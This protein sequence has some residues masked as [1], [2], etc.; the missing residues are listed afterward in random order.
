MI[1]SVDLQK[2]PGTIT[3]RPLDGSAPVPFAN[4]ELPSAVKKAGGAE[5]DW[6][7][8]HSGKKHFIVALA[9]AGAKL[10]IDGQVVVDCPAGEP[11][12]P[13]THR[14]SIKARASFTPS[15]GPHRVRIEL[16][17]HSAEQEATVLLAYANL[18]ICPWTEREIPNHAML[19]I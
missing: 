5:W 7:S 4:G 16:G 10:S 17:S 6:T 9:R 19:E 1:P 13:A 15:F 3:L 8:A 2:L 14:P 18:H 12:V 11:Y